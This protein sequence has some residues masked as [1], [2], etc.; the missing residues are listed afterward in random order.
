MRSG[1]RT[2][3]LGPGETYTQQVSGDVGQCTGIRADASAVALNVT[4]VDGSAASY[5]TL[6]PADVAT[7]PNASN[8]NWV[9]GAPPTPNKVDVKL[10]PAG[11]M[12]IYNNVGTVNVLADV[13]GY[14]QDHNHDD[15]YPRKLDGRVRRPGRRESIDRDTCIRHRVHPDRIIDDPDVQGSSLRGDAGDQ[16]CA[17]LDGMERARVQ[18][19][20]W[21]PCHHVHFALHRA[22]AYTSSSSTTST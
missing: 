8:L 22:R 21:P 4:A 14:Y 13:V 15:R 10:S 1:P 2:S 6:F 17:D 12:N 19:E 20:W 16:R 3:P 11:A 18:L 7:A 9:P 5:L